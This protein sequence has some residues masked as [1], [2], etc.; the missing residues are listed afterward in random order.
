MP[1]SIN[2]FIAGETTVYED[3]SSGASIGYNAYEDTPDEIVVTVYIYDSGYKSIE[4]GVD[5]RAIVCTKEV[6]I[7]LLMNDSDWKRSHRNVRNLQ[8][9]TIELD[10]GEVKPLKMLNVFFVFDRIYDDHKNESVTFLS[11]LLL[12]GLKGYIYK[13]RVS[14]CDCPNK[15]IEHEIKE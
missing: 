9:K 3:P 10:I 12:V 8:D 5:S 1:K 4:D 14:R 7:E 15:R 11:D 13:I 2:N 6:F